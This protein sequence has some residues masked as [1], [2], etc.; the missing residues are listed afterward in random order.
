MFSF[1]RRK[2][3]TFL[4]IDIGASQI[5][6]VELEKKE[7]R[8]E[9]KSYGLLPLFD[10][11]QGLNHSGLVD[12]LKM[13]V[14]NLAKAI[15]RTIEE[16]GVISRKACFSIPVYH[17]FATLVDL[18]IMPEKEIAAAIPFEARKYVPVPISEVFLDWS[19]VSLP[20]KQSGIQVLLIAVT[21]EM[22]NQYHRVIQLAGLTTQAIEAES[23]SLIRALVGNDKSAI[24]L[25]D[26]GARSTNISIIDG[27]Y[28]R[29]INNLDIGGIKLNRAV[30]SRTGLDLV[31][32][33]KE[34]VDQLLTS[35]IKGT[36]GSAVDGIINEAK[37]II[38]NYQTKYGRQVEKCIVAGSALQAPEFIDYFI[39][40]MGLATSIGNPFARIVY[41]SVLEP[42]LKLRGS[43]LA[44]AVGLA[45]REN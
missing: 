18:P 40:K 37:R 45:S 12:P 17:S 33:E 26:S 16:A 28:L 5:K 31:G 44:V 11:S 42:A 36:V 6:V 7:E 25:I 3:K 9:L 39:Q 8:F 14:E 13:P 15:K 34:R 10:Y 43:S 21:K 1:F 32:L 24:V 35:E 19:M 23:F 41:P 22:V 30:F 38:G 2:P 20:S 27:G 29:L 4:G